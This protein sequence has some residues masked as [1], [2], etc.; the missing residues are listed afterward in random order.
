MLFSES[1]ARAA[2]IAFQLARD[3]Q[4]DVRLVRDESGR[5]TF[6]LNCASADADF[7][8]MS[9]LRDT[10]LALGVYATEEPIRF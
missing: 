1:L 3:A 6:A 5:I 8:S 7:L 9:L 4:L 2:K 10:T